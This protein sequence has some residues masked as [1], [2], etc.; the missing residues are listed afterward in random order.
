MKVTE[1]LKKLRERSGLSMR[2][3]A[4]LLGYKTAS[5]YQR[6]EDGTVFTKESLPSHLVEKLIDHLSGKGEPPIQPAEILR[7]GGI[8]KV[9]VNKKIGELN[10]LG[11]RGATTNRVAP[12]VTAQQIEMLSERSISLRDTLKYVTVEENVSS[13]SFCLIVTDSSMGP[14][15]REGDRL[16]C[17]PHAEVR[18]GVY[19]VAKLDNELA[20]TVRRYRLKGV[21]QD[22]NPIVELVPINEDY[23]TNT[24]GPGTP[25]KIYARVVEH[26]R[27]V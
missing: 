4:E 17:D 11:L 13:E 25:G 8:Y 24:I 21:D 2:E 6:W 27:D 5:G 10:L 26:R 7:L 14:E 3:L 22:G 1:E 19:V 15:F 16:I 23:P 20:A 18:P 12:I 9:A